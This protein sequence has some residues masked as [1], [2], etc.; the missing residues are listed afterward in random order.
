MN[1]KCRRRA[2]RR[3]AARLRTWQSCRQAEV[4]CARRRDRAAPAQRGARS[5]RRAQRHAAAA[6]AAL[7]VGATAQLRRACTCAPS[8]ECWRSKHTRRRAVP[9]SQPAL[10][11]RTQKHAAAWESKSVWRKCHVSGL[12]SVLPPPPGRLTGAAGPQRRAWPP[13]TWRRHLGACPPRAATAGQV[14]S[15]ARR[16]AGVPARAGSGWRLLRCRPTALAATAPKK[17]AASPAA[18]AAK[19][20][21][22][23][24]GLAFAE[25]RPHR[26]AVCV[27]GSPTLGAATHQPR[28]GPFIHGRLAVA[29]PASVRPKPMAAQDSPAPPPGTGGKSALREFRP[30]S[31]GV[32]HVGQTLSHTRNKKF[33]GPEIGSG[34]DAPLRILPVGGLGEIGMNCMLVGNYDR[35]VILDAGLMFPECVAACDVALA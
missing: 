17:N 30:C 10:P 11:R 16:A 15:G 27:S 32:A 24:K 1:A 14:L 12:S 23:S 9:S 5:V 25:V 34:G 13:R 21:A 33:P 8:R 4:R 2:I 3:R 19:K 6:P 7:R 26:A 29:P 18:T 22:L 35:Y 31:D 28:F 20:L